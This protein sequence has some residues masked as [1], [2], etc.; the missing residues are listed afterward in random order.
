MKYSTYQG[1]PKHNVF[2]DEAVEILI[3]KQKRWAYEGC[4]VQ[5]HFTL[6]HVCHLGSKENQ[7]RGH[8]HVGATVSYT[9]NLIKSQ[10]FFSNH[11]SHQEPGVSV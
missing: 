10:E 8:F 3:Q 4:V 1:N 7:W 11:A 6:G 5:V 2:I 9:E